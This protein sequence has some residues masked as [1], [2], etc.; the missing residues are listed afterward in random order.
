MALR[1]LEDRAALTEAL[2]RRAEDRG[3]SV[4]ATRFRTDSGDLQSSI[5]VLRKLLKSTIAVAIEG[6]EDEASGDRG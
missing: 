1:S 6:E 2:A 3:H 4:S 5:E